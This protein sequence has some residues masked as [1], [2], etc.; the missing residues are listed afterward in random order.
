MQRS[1]IYA[2]AKEYYCS[3]FAPERRNVLQDLACVRDD[4]QE[5]E[6]RHAI[7][8]IAYQGVRTAGI[9]LIVAGIIAA[10]FT[11]GGSLILS[12]A[13]AAATTSS[14][15]A[16]AI[17][18]KVK[19][20]KIKEM[21][22]KAEQSL[23]KHEDTCLKMHELLRMLNEYLKATGDRDEKYF[24]SISESLLQDA[25]IPSKIAT[26]VGIV[27]G[28]GAVLLSV[29]DLVEINAG[30]MSDEALKIQKIINEL[31]S[32]DAEFRKFFEHNV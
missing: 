26:F 11:L 23:R 18:K 21:I 3:M 10:P 27:V 15:A 4:I 20:K 25:N 24:K 30:K 1:D 14:F 29:I 5:E 31:E 28:V 7:G 19:A 8:N 2:R 12:G 13:S 16:S 22:F 9:G 17:H 32:Q 6:R